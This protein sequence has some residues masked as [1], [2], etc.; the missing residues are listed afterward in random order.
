MAT[1]QGKV[2]AEKENR[3]QKNCAHSLNFRRVAQE[4]AKYMRKHN[5]R[6]WHDARGARKIRISAL[7]SKER[8]KTGAFEF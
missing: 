1:D 3:I 8:N 6:G 2:F 5:T 7:P 4:E